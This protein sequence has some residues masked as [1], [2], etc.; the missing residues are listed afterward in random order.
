MSK[1]LYAI[2]IS[3]IFLFNA[4]SSQAGDFSFGINTGVNNTKYYNPK[5]YSGLQL[6]VGLGINWEIQ[7]TVLFGKKYFHM[8]L[9]PALGLVAGSYILN[10]DEDEDDED[11]SWSEDLSSAFWVALL[12]SVIPETVSY[13]TPLSENIE[14]A[15]YVSPLQLDCFKTTESN[16]LPMLALGTAFNFDI[17]KYNMRLSPYAEYKF[18]YGNFLNQGYAMGLTLVYEAF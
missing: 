13:K 16:F 8:P 9:S 7:Y 18:E 4:Q 2:L 17:P 12:V 6:N 1:P 10:D 5:L 15:P 14:F 11:E 3:F